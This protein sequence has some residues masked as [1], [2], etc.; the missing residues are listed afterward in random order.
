MFLT[1]ICKFLDRLETL[2]FTT[3]VK[4]FT[5]TGVTCQKYY[6]VVVCQ[7][8]CFSKKIFGN[9]EKEPILVL[10]CKCTL[11]VFYTH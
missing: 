3:Y 6:A 5:F 4:D 7:K 8:T 9:G 2:Q 11:G 1:E 10:C